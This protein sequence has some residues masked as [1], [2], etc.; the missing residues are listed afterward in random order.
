[1]T[2]KYDA[3]MYASL[4]GRLADIRMDLD[5]ATERHRKIGERLEK[6]D[7]YEAI[8]STELMLVYADDIKARA[9]RLAE[10]ADFL[11]DILRARYATEELGG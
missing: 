11:L 9:K 8:A 2:D 7:L 4:G 1:M 5:A 3:A 6:G 10:T